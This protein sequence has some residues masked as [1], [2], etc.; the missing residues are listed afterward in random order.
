MAQTKLFL[1]GETVSPSW[2]VLPSASLEMALLAQ[3]DVRQGELA[4]V[5]LDLDSVA[6]EAGSLAMRPSSRGGAH[7][8]GSGPCADHAEETLLASMWPMEVS[9]ETVPLARVQGLHLS[10]VPPAGRCFHDLAPSQSEAAAKQAHTPSS[11]PSPGHCDA[12]ESF[13]QEASSSATP[14]A[15]DFASTSVRPRQLTWVSLGIQN[16]SIYA[17]PGSLGA[18][19]RFVTSASGMGPPSPSGQA[20]SVHDASTAIVGGNNEGQRTSGEGLR[21]SQ[22]QG[23]PCLSREEP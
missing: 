21:V 20:L 14:S 3:A 6:L 9:S 7:E 13:P 8:G 16:V 18:A 22:G 5:C 23:L 1:P 15:P 11:S 12:S 10:L 17:D 2:E 19:S 4:S